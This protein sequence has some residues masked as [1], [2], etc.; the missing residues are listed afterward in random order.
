M[1]NRCSSS[2]QVL[3]ISVI[4]P[5]INSQE[6]TLVDL[7]VLLD[8]V[9]NILVI[10]IMVLCF[11]VRVWGDGHLCMLISFFRSF[12]LVLNR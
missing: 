8:C 5:F 11:P 3:Y 10:G 4:L 7:M 2:A 1:T 9:A 6:K 12:V